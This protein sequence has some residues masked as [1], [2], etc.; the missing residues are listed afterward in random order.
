MNGNPLFRHPLSDYNP[1]LQSMQQAED[2]GI[3]GAIREYEA[4]QGDELAAKDRWRE[5]VYAR[6]RLPVEQAKALGP[7]EHGAYAEYRVLSEPLLGTIE[8]LGAIP[9]YTGAKSLGLMMD[10]RTSP[11]SLDEMAEGYR[12]MGR[13]WSQMLGFAP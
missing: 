6:D 10:E 9:A 4:G 1:L 11:P 5:Y 13:A 12:G 2:P 3:W 7:A 8:Q